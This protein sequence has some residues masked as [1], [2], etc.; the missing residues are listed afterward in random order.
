MITELLQD[1]QAFLAKDGHARLVPVLVQQVET[2]LGNSKSLDQARGEVFDYLFSV[3]MGNALE[4]YTDNTEKVDATAD[5]FSG[6]LLARNFDQWACPHIYGYLLL[7]RHAG[8]GEKA[9]AEAR[10]DYLDN[11]DED[12]AGFCD[13]RDKDEAG[14]CDERDKD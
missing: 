7:L 14:F 13:E 5:G 11:I 6:W 9:K 8:D 12:E 4:I 2:A 10:Q 3:E 1:V